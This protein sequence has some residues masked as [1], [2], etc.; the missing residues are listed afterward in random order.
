MLIFVIALTSIFL[1]CL[2]FSLSLTPRSAHLSSVYVHLLITND[3]CVLLYRVLTTIGA[4]TRQH[5]V[6]GRDRK[7]EHRCFEETDTHGFCSQ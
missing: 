6:Q 1:S 4:T 5:S 7:V 2:F 3:M